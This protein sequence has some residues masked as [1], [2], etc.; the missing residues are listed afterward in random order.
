[1]RSWAGRARRHSTNDAKGTVP[2]TSGG[3]VGHD[4]HDAAA[5]AG[6]EL[7][8]AGGAGEERVVL[9]QAD[10]VA[11]LEA[12]AALANDDLAARDLL[13]GEDLHAEH[14][15]VGVAPV[16]RGAE[17]LLVRHLSSYF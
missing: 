14:L 15:R 16:A 5:A 3:V 9:A 6:G 4:V 10:A 17:A 2:L 13:A 11:G 8:G 1:A 7:D 12:R